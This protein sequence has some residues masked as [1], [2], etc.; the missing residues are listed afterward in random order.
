MPTCLYER[1]HVS[2]KRIH[3]LLVRKAAGLQGGA[4]ASGAPHHT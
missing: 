2:R 4:A 3:L 1:V